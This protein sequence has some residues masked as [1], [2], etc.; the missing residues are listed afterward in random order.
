MFNR[1]D[2]KN[3][4]PETEK[5]EVKNKI[6]RFLDVIEDEQANLDKKL[7]GLESALD[8][9]TVSIRSDD[10]ENG[11]KVTDFYH[12]LG[13]IIEKHTSN[14]NIDENKNVEELAGDV[15]KFILYF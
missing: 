13:E 9:I 7:K 3:Y 6:L 12:R 15:K 14:S 1:I 8:E 2:K 11:D 5:A 4:S 10:K